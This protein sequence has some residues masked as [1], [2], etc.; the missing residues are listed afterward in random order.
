MNLFDRFLLDVTSKNS[1]SIDEHFVSILDRI[2]SSESK[3]EKEELR[4]LA[5]GLFGVKVKLDQ[6][7]TV[8]KQ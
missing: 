7:F 8:S 5:K 2:E 4:E 6:V 1:K 3:N